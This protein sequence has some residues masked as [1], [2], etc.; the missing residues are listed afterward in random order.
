[1]SRNVV[2]GMPFVVCWWVTILSICTSPPREIS[3]VDRPDFRKASR[4]A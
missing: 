3:Q 2:S 4:V 1:M